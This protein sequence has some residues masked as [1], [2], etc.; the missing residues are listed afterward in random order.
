MIAIT[1]DYRNKAEQ[2]IYLIYYTTLAFINLNYFFYSLICTQYRYLIIAS[3]K[4]C[5]PLHFGDS[6]HRV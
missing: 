2:N 1:P 4:V 5:T 6:A 3:A